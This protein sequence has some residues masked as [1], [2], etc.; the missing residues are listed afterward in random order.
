MNNSIEVVCDEG[1]IP[2]S[3]ANSHITC[4]YNIESDLLEWEESSPISC[5]PTS[6]NPHP[7]FRYIHEIKQYYD[8]GEII[9]FTCPNGYQ[10][11][12]RCVLDK[13]TGYGIWNYNGSCTGLMIFNTYNFLIN[14]TIVYII[15]C[16]I[17]N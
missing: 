3:R 14:N 16:P 4:T 5:L 7:D 17:L 10:I 8:I 1:Y 12:T 11:R 13:I 9:K 6:C 2:E 15:C